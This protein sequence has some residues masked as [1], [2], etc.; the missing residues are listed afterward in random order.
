MDNI[1]SYILIV[2]IVVGGIGLVLMSGMPVVDS[3]KGDLQFRDSEQFLREFD[4]YVKDV[5]SEGN[6][7]IRVIKSSGG[8]FQIDAN[9]NLVQ[10]RQDSN[11][12][13]YLTR[14]I[15]NDMMIIA[16]NDVDCF[17]S[18]VNKDGR[19]EYVMEN[20]YLQ[21]V[22]QKANGTYDTAKNVLSMKQ[23]HNNRTIVV[24]DSSI[25]IDNDVTTG[26]GSGYSEI[27]AKRDAPL[28][29]VHFFMNSTL[30]YDI[31]YTLYAGADFVVAEVVNIR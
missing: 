10:F 28:C 27:V 6:G 30:D 20:S 13:D 7:S 25:I 31:Y 26:K 3:M 8:D 4:S 21:A 11:V 22:F 24:L 23:M 5:V 17:E 14:R 29:R 16:G 1:V 18:D 19:M 9:E 15:S 12:F 2:A